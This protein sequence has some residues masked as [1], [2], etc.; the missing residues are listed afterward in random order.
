MIAQAVTILLSNIPV[1]MFIAAI[2]VPSIVRRP[3]SRP[4][5]Y[6]S[7]L[8]L[9]SVGVESLWGGLFHVF[10]PSMASAQIGWQSSPY[11]FEVGVAD[12]AL[13]VVAIAAF[14]RSLSFKSA[15]A[16]M[17]VLFDAGVLVGHFHQAFGSGNFSPDNFG[18]MQVITALH[19]IILPILL[20]LVWRQEKSVT[21]PAAAFA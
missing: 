10:F 2:V 17:A 4:Y 11:E 7:W 14:W 3:R 1:L 16:V 9:L 19:V 15:V 21:R 18:A 5:R 6:F 13:G 8:L 20:V 12:I